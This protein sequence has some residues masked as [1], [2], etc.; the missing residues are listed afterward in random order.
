MAVK[1]FSTEYPG[2]QV[3]GSILLRKHGVRFD[4][5][6]SIYYRLERQAVIEEGHRVGRRPG[7][8]AQKAAGELAKLEGSATLGPG[9]A[10]PFNEKREAEQGRREAGGQRLQ[11]SRPGRARFTFGQV[12][13]GA[14]IEEADRTKDKRLLP[15]RARAVPPLHSIRHRRPA[16]QGRL[17]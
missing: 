9:G 4:R 8:T 3:S 11:G 12:F 17:R 2:V 14:Y 13:D 6:F 10:R 1:R 7:W 15:T 5:Y 16:A